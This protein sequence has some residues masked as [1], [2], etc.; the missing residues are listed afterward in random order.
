MIGIGENSEEARK[1][2]AGAVITVKY[3]GTNI[4]GT[5]QFPKFYRE[6]NDVSWS[7]LIKT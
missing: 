2:Q 3:Q 6:R 5:L 1:V 7:N 4:Y